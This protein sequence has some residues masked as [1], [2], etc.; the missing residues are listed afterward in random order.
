VERDLP[1]VVMPHGGPEDRDETG[2]DWL[3]QFLASRGYAVLQPQFRG[4]TGLG[5]AHAN[6]GRQ[7]WGLRMQDDVTDGVRA[8]ITE[9]IVDPKRVCIVGW[10]YGGYSALAGAAFT[11]DLYACAASIGGV[12][13]LP[14]MLATISRDSGRESD[15]FAYWREH[16]GSPFNAD[17]IGKS[18]ARAA[19]AVRAPVLLLHGTDDTV[20]PIEQSRLMAT[21]LRAAKKPVELI[22]LTGEDHWMKTSSESRIRTLT[23]LE[24]F[25]W[26]YIGGAPPAAA[27]ASN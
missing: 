16:I 26:K 13:D 17:V 5:R 3:A 23:E 12:S 15:A 7:Q 21:A 14:V 27:S 18:P 10:S 25:L 2:F 6:A 19:M 9:G 4:S 24:R 8:L 1:L 20:V 11:P 22:E